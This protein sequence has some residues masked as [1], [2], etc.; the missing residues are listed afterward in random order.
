MLI[1]VFMP[2]AAVRLLMPKTGDIQKLMVVPFAALNVI[3]VKYS[4][5]KLNSGGYLMITPL[6]S[7]ACTARAKSG[8]MFNVN[9]AKEVPYGN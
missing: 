4:V 9:F 8:G 6:N 7:C 3:Q 2:I 1:S 5:N